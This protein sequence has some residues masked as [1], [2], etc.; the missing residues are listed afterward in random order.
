MCAR[1]CVY[2]ISDFLLP[3]L[4]DVHHLDKLGINSDELVNFLAAA[5]VVIDFEQNGDV[6][7]Y[8]LLD[9]TKVL[10]SSIL[11]SGYS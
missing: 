2:C 7:A 9:I 10:N 6:V 8:K 5:I 1:V 11:N 3:V 4:S